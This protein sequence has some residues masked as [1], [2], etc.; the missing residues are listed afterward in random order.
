MTSDD[1]LKRTEVLIERNFDAP[2]ERAFRAWTEPRTM[3]RWM[4]AGLGDEP[5]AECDLR[6]GG[7]Y[8]VY[9]KF[10]GGRHQGAGWSGMC[11]LFVEIVPNE[12]LIDTVHWDADVRSVRAAV[13]S[14]RGESTAAGAPR[15]GAAWARRI[16]A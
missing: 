9:T 15:S 7:A 12:K 3:A 6:V 14:R 5:W 10:D 4:W 8:R 11:G 2:P 13:C 1:Y 16:L